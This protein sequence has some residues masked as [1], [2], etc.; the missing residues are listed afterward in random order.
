MLHYEVYSLFVMV[1]FEY[2]MEKRICVGM[3]CFQSVQFLAI[4]H[5]ILSVHSHLTIHPVYSRL[6]KNI[7]YASVLFRI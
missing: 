1:N 4:L 2:F 3:I 7:V 6:V 5:S